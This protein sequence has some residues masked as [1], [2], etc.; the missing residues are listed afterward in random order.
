MTEDPQLKQIRDDWIGRQREHGNQP[1]AVLMKGLHPLINETIDLWHRAVMRAAF[2]GRPA[3]TPGLPSLDIGCGYG[4]LAGQARN[5][6]W[7]RSSESTSPSSSAWTSSAT[8]GR[9]SAVNCR[10]CRFP[11]RR[12]QARIR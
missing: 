4:R 7:P 8:M 5:A 12:S 2:D 6:V 11:M 9:R 1:R 3:T 10:A